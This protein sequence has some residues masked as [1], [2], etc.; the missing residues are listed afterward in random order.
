MF[1]FKIEKVFEPNNHKSK[2]NDIQKIDCNDLNSAL[3]IDFNL[4]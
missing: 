3:E 4:L 1:S 2:H